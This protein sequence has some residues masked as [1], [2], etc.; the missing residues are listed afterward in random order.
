MPVSE[1]ILCLSDLDPISTSTSRIVD[2]G[3]GE[4]ND[5]CSS[6]YDGDEAR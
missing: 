3:F 1:R 5:C 2:C 4:L 6:A